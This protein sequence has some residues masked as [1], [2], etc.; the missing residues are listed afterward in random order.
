[1]GFFG[2]SRVTP[3]DGSHQK[4]TPAQLRAARARELK[5]KDAKEAARKDARVRR[6]SR[7]LGN[8]DAKKW[9]W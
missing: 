2:P 6:M 5:A 3:R 1:M 4:F 8:P 7:N 9:T